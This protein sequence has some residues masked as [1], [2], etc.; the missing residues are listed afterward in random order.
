MASHGLVRLLRHGQGSVAVCSGSPVQPDCVLCR[1]LALCSKLNRQPSSRRFR[2][3]AGL[4]CFWTTLSNLMGESW[5]SERAEQCERLARAT[6]DASLRAE[7]ET[8][9]RLWLQIAEAGARRVS[10]TLK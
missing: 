6:R 10:S 4:T 5:Y 2:V 1:P 3:P 9:R 7:L 8:E